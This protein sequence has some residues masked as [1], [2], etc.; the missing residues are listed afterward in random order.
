MQVIVVGASG[1]VGAG[2]QGGRVTQ[3]FSS[4]IPPTLPMYP[5]HSPH[6]LAKFEWTHRSDGATDLKL[7]SP[8]N[9]TVPILSIWGLSRVPFV[10]FP[11]GFNFFNSLGISQKFVQSVVDS[12][13]PVGPIKGHVLAEVGVEGTGGIALWSR[14]ETS[15]ALD[16]DGGFLN[17]G[18]AVENGKV[19]FTVAPYPS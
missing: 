13:E 19:R 18:F 11:V 7:Y 2:P 1:K 6:R 3:A 4:A 12:Y 17:V 9:S 16:L 8:P 15:D 14:F 10:S 5:V